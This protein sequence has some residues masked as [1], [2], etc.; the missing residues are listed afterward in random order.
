[1]SPDFEIQLDR[2]GPITPADERPPTPRL[3][4]REPGWQVRLKLGSDREFCYMTAPGQ[5]F[6]H[7]IVDGE[8]Y[9]V[10]GDEKV[11]L[12]CAGRRGLL[13]PE[14]KALREP[15]REVLDAG[16]AVGGY[17]LRD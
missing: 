1:M 16:E 2:L 13:E 4:V 5:E 14:P 15:I 11:C 7:R 17:D 12:P 8:I 10:R 3:F 6:Y 9:V